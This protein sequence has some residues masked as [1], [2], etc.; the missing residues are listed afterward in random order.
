[1]KSAFAM[2]LLLGLIA[3]CLSQKQSPR[4]DNVNIETV[5]SNDRVL[6]NYIKCLLEQGACTREGR[7]LKRKL[8][9]QFYFSF[10]AWRKTKSKLKLKFEKKSVSATVQQIF[11]FQCS[12]VQTVL[13]Y[14][15][16][17]CL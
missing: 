15:S 12:I 1:M 9:I 6:T 16:R 14:Y 13:H 7:D 2:V 8:Y 11:H 3:I 17:F 5:L 10:N 4:L